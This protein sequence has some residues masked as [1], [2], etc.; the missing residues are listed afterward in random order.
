MSWQAWRCWQDVARLG[1]SAP[2]STHG[3]VG[4]SM[5]APM[6]SYTN[7]AL[8]CILTNFCVLLIFL[9]EITARPLKT[10]A[11]ED[12]SLKQKNCVFWS[13]CA[14]KLL[15][16]DQL[17]CYY[18]YL[19]HTGKS[20]FSCY[21]LLCNCA[22][23]ACMCSHHCCGKFSIP[24]FRAIAS[25]CLRILWNNVACFFFYFCMHLLSFAWTTILD[26]Q[27]Y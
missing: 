9:P 5:L 12:K 7:L 2:W 26:D 19:L 8:T 25:C 11:I 20:I 1:L 4:G 17:G 22:R 3:R 24:L 10:K 21:V 14:G 27:W 18:S 6:W 23:Y 16:R 13:T 15:S